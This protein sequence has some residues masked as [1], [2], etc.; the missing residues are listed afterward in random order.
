MG[1]VGEYMASPV[2][3]V[4]H[5]ATV[6]EVAE[7]MKSK[8]TASA[9][10]ERGG[11]FVGVVTDADFTRKVALGGLPVDTTKIHAVMSAPIV[12]IDCATPMM[13][14]HELMLQSRIRHLAVTHEG[15]IVGMLSVTD[16][17]RYY[18]KVEE[19]LQELSIRDGLTG[20]F[21]RRHFDKV[22]DAEWKR[23][24]RRGTPVSL[25][26]LDIDS[27]KIYNDTHGH[28]AGDDCLKK[29]A[30]AVAGTL[31]RP[32]DIVARYGGEEF[33]VVLSDTDKEGAF[34]LA[35]VVRADIES[36]KIE[37]RRSKVSPYITASMGVSSDIPLPGS[38][39]ESLIAN[40][41]KA[42]YLAKRGGRNQVVRG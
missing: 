12:A 35:E 9:L 29:V 36:L 7:F 39:C 1:T 24:M 18:S 3:H 6:R 33:A 28:Q 15:K 19:R 25:I 27:F 38:S 37:H 14:A 5:E 8:R 17:F 42:L 20:V 23:A 40:A 4:N 32:A 13:N 10:V 30:G 41:D 2:L 34:K 21:N 26:M 31:K 16:F 22:I 11:D